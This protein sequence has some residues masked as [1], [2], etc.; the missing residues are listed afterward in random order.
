MLFRSVLDDD[1]DD[2]NSNNNNDNDNDNDDNHFGVEYNAT[3]YDG[4]ENSVATVHLSRLSDSPSSANA[5]AGIA[6]DHSTLSR[7]ALS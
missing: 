6:P 1:L 3:V 2:D 7:N 4:R 5:A